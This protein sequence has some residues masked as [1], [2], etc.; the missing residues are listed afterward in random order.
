MAD[1]VYSSARTLPTS[2]SSPADGARAAED[3]NSARLFVALVVALPIQVIKML[4]G[5]ESEANEIA[6]R[7]ES[8]RH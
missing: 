2:A 7:N 8:V 4:T 1:T 6:R 5:R 3:D